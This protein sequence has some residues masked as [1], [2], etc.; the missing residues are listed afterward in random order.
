MTSFRTGSIGTPGNSRRNAGQNLTDRP[1]Q[2]EA[3]ADDKLPHGVDR[4]PGEQPAERGAKPYG[5][6]RTDG[7]RG[8]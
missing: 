8:R 4:D 6:P 5:S 7:G 3:E 2:T 1:G